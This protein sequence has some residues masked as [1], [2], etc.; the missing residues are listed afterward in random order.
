MRSDSSCRFWVEAYDKNGK[1]IGRSDEKYYTDTKI[2]YNSR[3]IYN[4]KAQIPTVKVQVQGK[5]LKKGTDYT[6]SASGNTYPGKGKIKISLKGNYKGTITEELTI[7]LK[8]SGITGLTGGR[9]CF[10]AKWKKASLGVTEYQ[11]QY[12]TSKNFKKAKTVR[13]RNARTVRTKITGVKKGRYY[14][15]IRTAGK[16][17]GKVYYSGWSSAK[18]VTVK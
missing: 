3:L 1:L 17:K 4:G 6:V 15:R 18:K 9:K 8:S 12:S 5:T 2:T 16:I 10:T 13:V 14:V 7:A 11:I